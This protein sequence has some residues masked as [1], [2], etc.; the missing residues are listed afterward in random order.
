MCASKRK[1]LRIKGVKKTY[2]L[3][4]IC[5]PT[6]EEACST[7]HRD[8]ICSSSAKYRKWK[9]HCSSYS[10]RPRESVFWA[11]ITHATLTSSDC[12]YSAVIGS[13][14]AVGGA[15]MKDCRI[16]SSKAVDAQRMKRFRSVLEIPPIGLMSAELQSYFVKYPRKD[17]STR[18]R[19][20]SNCPCLEGFRIDLGK[21]LNSNF[22][23]R[24]SQ[25]EN[26]LFLTVGAAQYQ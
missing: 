7:C 17:S 24:H 8:P 13:S 9:A 21:C 2:F 25:L 6:Y 26:S 11:G 3:T 15:S 22:L 23:S 1:P 18:G 4:S 19:R 14:S 10:C 20:V 16:G 5:L 12:V